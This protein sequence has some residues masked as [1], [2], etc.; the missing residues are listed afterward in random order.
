MPESHSSSLHLGFA[1][2]GAS[3]LGVLADFNFLH[4][5][6]EGGTIMGPLFLDDFDLR[7]FNLCLASPF[8][9]GETRAQGKP[10]SPRAP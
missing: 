1:A 6:P 3:V 8:H 4:R 7:A 9:P 5:F 10:G 2:E